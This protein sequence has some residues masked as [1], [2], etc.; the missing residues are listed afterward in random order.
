MVRVSLS[1]SM[2]QG[3]ILYFDFCLVNNNSQMLVTTF[4][5]N[6]YIVSS[7]APALQLENSG[8][9][10]D[11][12][13][14]ILEKRKARISKRHTTDDVRS[15]NS[16]FGKLDMNTGFS[17]YSQTTSLN[18]SQSS[19]HGFS[20]S[21]EGEMHATFHCTACTTPDLNGHELVFVQGDGNCAPRTVSFLCRGSEDDWETIK[22]FV[23]NYALN[24]YKK[25]SAAIGLDEREV[26]A[27]A[28]KDSWQSEMFFKISADAL[29]TVFK[30]YGF[31]ASDRVYRPHFES[32]KKWVK[33]FF[34]KGH[35]SPIVKRYVN[36]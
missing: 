27:L 11:H 12:F 20:E 29:R 9:P 21:L 10:K 25:L 24:N 28:K 8:K 22:A 34:W 1:S 35:F 23:A 33:V 13:Q 32:P 31:G 2:S 18:T 19:Y 5:R 36:A 4:F 14:A 16:E 3:K 30:I 6:L 7:L 26:N 17:P 15:L